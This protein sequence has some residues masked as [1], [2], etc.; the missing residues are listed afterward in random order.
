VPALGGSYP[1]RSI[2]CSGA[3][4]PSAPRIVCH[5]ARV[6]RRAAFGPGPRRKPAALPKAD[7]GVRDAWLGEVPQPLPEAVAALDGARNA[8]QARDAA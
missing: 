4:S 8:H 1:R 2:A 5:G 3:R 7:E 6:R